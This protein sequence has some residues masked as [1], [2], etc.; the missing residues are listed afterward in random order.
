[1]EDG[2][3][4]RWIKRILLYIA[5]MIIPYSFFLD[6]SPE[7]GV[8]GLESILWSFSNYEPHSGLIVV[9]S[10]PLVI[11]FVLTSLPCFVFLY[12]KD[13][14]P[15][16]T[17]LSDKAIV[18]S[19]LIFFLHIAAIVFFPAFGILTMA[20]YTGI[21]VTYPVFMA[22]VLIPYVRWELERKEYER[23]DIWYQESKS[24]VRTS[25]ES[26]RTGLIMLYL[27]LFSPQNIAFSWSTFSL[28]AP[29]WMFYL[30][31][32]LDFE[33]WF[34]IYPVG[35]LIFFSII[36]IP[37]FVFAYKVWMYTRGL[38]KETTTILIGIVSLVSG[39][40]FSM[41]LFLFFMMFLPFPLLFIV[42][43]FLIK[44]SRQYGEKRRY[45]E[46]ATKNIEFI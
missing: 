40:A 37:G 33:F 19:L 29:T 41:F 28:H 46:N 24:Q 35:F 5:L 45:V 17:P 22:F 38:A 10:L 20:V 26:S 9:P 13:Q 12:F 6:I 2:V 14:T 44:S 31:Y 18:A 3:I 36:Y 4:R 30:S 15:H 23:A 21:S 39:L 32:G 7:S 16:Y 42:G 25:N 1:M 11:L 34:L 43:L 8:R 27:A